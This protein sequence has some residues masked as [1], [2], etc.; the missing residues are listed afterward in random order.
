[1]KGWY[2]STLPGKNTLFGLDKIIKNWR[3]P[4]QLYIFTDFWAKQL[5]FARLVKHSYLPPW[6]VKPLF[7][8]K[9]FCPYRVNKI[10]LYVLRRHVIN[11][12]FNVLTS[13]CLSLFIGRFV[14]ILNRVKAGKA[15]ALFFRSLV[16]VVQRID[17]ELV[18]STILYIVTLVT[19][20]QKRFRILIRS[21]TYSL[22]CIKNKQYDT[23]W[24]P[25]EMMF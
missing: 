22:Q 25:G 19:N 6:K 21:W 18:L 13:N 3:L 17:V 10:T 8:R 14:T 11:S 20:L 9:G 4:T 7:T 23:I 1:M 5:Y 24:F 15:D 12:I 16:I 2:I